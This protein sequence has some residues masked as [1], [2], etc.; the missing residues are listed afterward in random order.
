MG[1]QYIFKDGNLCPVVACVRCGYRIEQSKDGRVIYNWHRKEL[2]QVGPLLF[3]HVGCMPPRG[4]TIDDSMVGQ[5]IS[6][7]DPEIIQLIFD[8][9]DYVNKHLS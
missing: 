8:E 4:K 5:R 3:F 7:T 9:I 6:M 1:I 2:R